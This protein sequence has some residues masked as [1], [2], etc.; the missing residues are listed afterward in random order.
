MSEPAKERRARQKRLFG[1]LLAEVESLRL[2][3]TAKDAEIA[4][5]KALFTIECEA[6]KSGQREFE[7]AELKARIAE[8]E[9]GVG[10]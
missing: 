2:S 9:K 7:I 6:N 3:L 5:L 1:R 8:L 4:G 10:G